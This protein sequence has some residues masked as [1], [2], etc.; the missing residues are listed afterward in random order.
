MHFLR[1]IV[2]RFLFAEAIIKWNFGIIH[3]LKCKSKMNSF[4]EHMLSFAQNTPV[5]SHAHT[6]IH[7]GYHTLTHTD[8]HSDADSYTCQMNKILSY[9]KSCCAI[10]CLLLPHCLT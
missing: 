3:A 5:D 4:A 1:F 9:G 7:S 2:C 10:V 6:L 8:T